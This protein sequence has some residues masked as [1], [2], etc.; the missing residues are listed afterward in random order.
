MNIIG[1]IHK[2]NSNRLVKMLL[3]Y[4]SGVLR[5]WRLLPAASKISRVALPGAPSPSPTRFAP[6]VYPSDTSTLTVTKFRK[7]PRDSIA[8]I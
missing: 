5:G 4:A 1:R 3:P 7:A 6:A 8:S 2:L